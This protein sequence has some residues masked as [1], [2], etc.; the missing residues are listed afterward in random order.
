M[1]CEKIVWFAYS[2]CLEVYILL[3]HPGMKKALMLKSGITV[4][5]IFYVAALRKYTLKIP[6]IY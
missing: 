6:R 1:Y 2:C 4:L 5:C 3:P